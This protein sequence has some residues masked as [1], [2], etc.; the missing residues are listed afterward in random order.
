MTYLVLAR[1][2]RPQ[3][4]A[5]IVGQEHVTRTLQNAIRTGHVAH[6]FLFTGVRGVGKTT[7]ARVLA[8]ALN[9]DRGPAPEPCNACV[10]C[11]QIAQGNSL[12]VVEIDGAS[13]TG[14]DDVRA[15]I[16]NV[17]YR[18]AQCRF[19]IYIVDEVHM[20]STSAFNALLKTLEEPPA[21]VKFIFATTDPHKVPATVQSRC[22]RF[23]FRRLPL[24]LIV[25]HLGEIAAK[26]GLE[27]SEK[28]LF[29][30]A[31]ESEGSMRDAQSLL[32]QTIAFAG[33]R[34]TDDQIFAALG[35]ADRALV[36]ELASALIARDPSRVLALVENVYTCG[37]DLR[38]FVRD[39]IEHFR[40]IAVVQAGASDLLKE[41]LPVEELL[42]VQKQAEAVS[43]LDVER[44]FRTLLQAEAEIG[45]SPVPKLCL[46]MHLLRLAMAEPLVSL[47]TLAEELRQLA[48]GKPSPRTT[49]EDQGKL[50]PRGDKNRQSR[51]SSAPEAIPERH[52]QAQG[53]AVANATAP[54]PA[55]VPRGE[56]RESLEFAEGG[57]SRWRAF[58]E[59]V[60][61]RRRFIAAHLQA[62]V[63]VEWGQ[64]W[65]KIT[66]PRGIHYQYLTHGGRAQEL[67]ALAS[68]F[69]ASPFSVHIEAVSEENSSEKSQRQEPMKDLLRQVLEVPAVRK[70]VEIL[71]A[72]IREVRERQGVQEKG[73]S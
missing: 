73:P 64:D 14:V 39:C 2:W 54:A 8:K 26:E 45:R 53:T 61:Q 6:A 47:A 63:G 71:G 28:G 30:L 43:F 38:R 66:I 18:P 50:P 46:E 42:A 62:K 16:E 27:I 29:F 23:D 37:D 57:D 49:L 1:R 21:H 7:A 22:Q 72:E 35:L 52:L 20:L 40:N 19:K 41:E 13:N 68:E 48:D 69:F 55:G 5:D 12:D 10:H 67:A 24:S 17:R 25:R 60:G 58:L 59:F 36:V 31:R 44:I 34:I 51:D 11:E 32:D 33:R 65:L 4:F 56:G 15:I 3:T 9:C 70:T